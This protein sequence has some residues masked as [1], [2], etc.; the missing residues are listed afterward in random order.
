M[1]SLT[2]EFFRTVSHACPFDDIGMPIDPFNPAAFPYGNANCSLHCEYGKA[3]PF[4]PIRRDS[5]NEPA[6][7]PV[8]QRLTFS[9]VTLIAAGSS[10]PPVLTLVRGSCLQ[11]HSSIEFGMQ[12]HCSCKLL[13]GSSG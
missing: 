7:I 1:L 4:S 3:G 5:T 9:A 2:V 10:I 13:L 11:C 8:P 6:V 12:Q